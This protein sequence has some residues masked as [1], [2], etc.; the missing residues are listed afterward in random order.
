MGLRMKENSNRR[1]PFRAGAGTE[2]GIC[3][4]LCGQHSV[5]R[6]SLS[7]FGFVGS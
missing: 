4:K 5:V 7:L 1:F 2:E 3:G 6:F